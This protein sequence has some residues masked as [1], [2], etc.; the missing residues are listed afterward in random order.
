MNKFLDC[1]LVS[2]GIA[3]KHFWV[4]PVILIVLMDLISDQPVVPMVPGN[5]IQ[6]ARETLE[7]P[8]MGVM[9]VLE[10]ME[11]HEIGP[12]KQFWALNQLTKLDPKTLEIDG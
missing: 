8:K 2:Q 10:L 6:H 7:K 11:E 5:L 1:V 3:Q 9:V 12:L 4:K